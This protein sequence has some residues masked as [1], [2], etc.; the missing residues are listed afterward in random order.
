M[1]WWNRSAAQA[2]ETE[3]DSVEM[4]PVGAAPTSA[5][6]DTGATVATA[7][8]LPAADTAGEELARLRAENATLST[9]RNDFRT[10]YQGALRAEAKRAA[11]IATGRDM[12][13][14][15]D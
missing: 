1:P 6:A 7:A 15:V 13:R 2:E 10:R 14:T 5:G 12:A 9:E 4:P 11:I 8:A 3:Q